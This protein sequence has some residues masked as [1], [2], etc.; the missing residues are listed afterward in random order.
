MHLSHCFTSLKK[1][2]V[3][4]LGT[5]ECP[6][7]CLNIFIGGETVPFECP[8]QSR[9][10]VEDAGNQGRTAGGVI[11]ALPTEGGNMVDRCYC[12]VRSCIVMQKNDSCCEN[13]RSL[14]PSGIFSH[15]SVSQ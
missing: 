11:Q 13:A 5:D 9:E 10:E 14:L 15:V 8:I 3:G 7:G 6:Y 1:V 2:K 4:V 12:H